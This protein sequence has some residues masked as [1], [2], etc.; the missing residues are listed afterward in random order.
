MIAV[1]RMLTAMR[2]ALRRLVIALTSVLVISA[3]FA[4]G[5]GVYAAALAL[6]P[7]VLI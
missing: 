6:W 1:W 5:I 4:A 2:N 3:V 7:L